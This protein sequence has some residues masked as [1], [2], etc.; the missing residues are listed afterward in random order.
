[1]TLC[2]CGHA[3]EEHGER[4]GCVARVWCRRCAGTHTCEC[5]CGTGE[6]AEAGREDCPG[7]SPEQRAAW[8]A[9]RVRAAAEVREVERFY[10]RKP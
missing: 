9:E 1:M 6:A 2:H 8:D 10:G 5:S 7:P 3:V 4:H